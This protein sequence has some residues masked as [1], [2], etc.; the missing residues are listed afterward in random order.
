MADTATARAYDIS[1]AP[2]R[3]PVD[4]VDE[5]S[6]LEAQELAHDEARIQERRRGQRDKVAEY[7][8]QTFWH[9]DRTWPCLYWPLVA[10][11]TRVKMFFPPLQLAV[12]KFPAPTPVQRKEAMFKGEALRRIGIRYV[13]LFPETPLRKVAIA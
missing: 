4:P 6:L 1:V 12:D 10:Q 3:V 11:Q 5:E 2:R 7:L 8:G 13:A 9:T